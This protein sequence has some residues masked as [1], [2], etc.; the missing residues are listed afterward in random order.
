MHPVPGTNLC[1]DWVDSTQ[2]LVQTSAEDLSLVQ[3]ELYRVGLRACF[4]ARPRARTATRCCLI[5]AARNHVLE[6]LRRTRCCL[7]PPT[8]GAAMSNS[9]TSRSSSRD[10][11]VPGSGARAGTRVLN[12]AE[13]FFV[14]ELQ[15][16][17]PH[18]AGP[19]ISPFLCTTREADCVRQNA[20]ASSIRPAVRLCTPSHG[21]N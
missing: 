3:F 13:L 17:R 1:R 5:P 2:F 6:R 19:R 21:M 11:R 18:A 8:A 9:N 14:A 10:T 16:V 20:Y 15:D 7:I 12:K 4:Q